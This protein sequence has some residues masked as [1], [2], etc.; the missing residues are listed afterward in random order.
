MALSDDI[1]NAIS[2]T[3]NQVTSTGV[4]A[5]LAAGEAYGAAQLNG[6]AQSNVVAATSAT[7]AAMSGPSAAPGSFQAS[8]SNV[9]SQIA[10]N[11]VLKQYG[12]YIVIGVVAFIVIRKL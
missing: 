1:S 6:M 8:L 2:A 11:A 3:W 4:P 10:G 12:A 7:K 5:V 9:F